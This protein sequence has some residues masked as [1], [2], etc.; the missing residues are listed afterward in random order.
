MGGLSFLT[1]LFLYGALGA[2]IPLLLHLIKRT[3]ARRIFPTIRFLKL[4]SQQVV[5]QQ[6]IRR[7]VLLMLRMAACAVLAIIFARPFLND[8][9]AAAFVGSTPKAM[10]IVMDTSYSI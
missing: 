1:P 4:S 6:K 5:R 9:A 8:S 2:V 7:I 10:A 3:R